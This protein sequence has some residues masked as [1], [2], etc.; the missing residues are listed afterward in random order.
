MI[1]VIPAIIPK[2]FEDLK[3]K[4]SQVSRLV[5]LVQVDVMDGRLTPEA[6]WPYLNS[7]DPD[8]EDIKKEEGEFPFWQKLDFEVDLMVKE[9]ERVW[10]DWITAGAKRAIFHFESTEDI[11]ALL[12]DFREKL[13]KK[14]SALYTELGLAIDIDTP[15]EE[16]YPFVPELDFVQFMGIAKIGFQGEPFDERVIE[17]IKS[18]KQN[19]SE[20]TVSVDGGVSLESAPSLVEAGAGRLVSGSAIFESGDVEETIAKFKGLG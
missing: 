11:G 14:D 12:K 17:K 1:E 20:K 9:P 16:I 10:F 5:P 15:N 2:D 4:M 19:F 3:E 13:P 6:S 7:P 8:F 18:F